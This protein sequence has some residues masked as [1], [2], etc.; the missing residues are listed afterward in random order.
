MMQQIV[1]LQKFVT[2]DH[3]YPDTVSERVT[4]SRFYV[5]V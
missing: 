3:T 2:K 5:Y 1:F 4:D